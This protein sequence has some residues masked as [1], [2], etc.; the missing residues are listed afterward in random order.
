MVAYDITR[1]GLSGGVWFAALW[2]ALV[3]VFFILALERGR[4]RAF[5]DRSHV[6]VVLTSVFVG[7]AIIIVFMGVVRR[8]DCIA[9]FRAGDFETTQGVI[10]HLERYGR[11]PLHWYRFRLGDRDF[12]VRRDLVGA[13]GFAGRTGSSCL[14]KGSRLVIEHDGDRIYRVIVP[15]DD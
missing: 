11:A 10:S 13:C 8:Q 6:A 9:G 4:K 7:V 12:A 2:T 1:A 3:L 15:A 5:P 14:N